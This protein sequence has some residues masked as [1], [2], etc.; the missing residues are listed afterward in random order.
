MTTLE[1]L[2]TNIWYTEKNHDLNPAYFF[3][4][5]SALL[6][7]A[8]IRLRNLFYD[9][10]LLGQ[11]G[12]RCPVISVG[13]L[14]VGGTGK[15]PM[16]I[17]LA[18]LMAGWGLKP[19][20][21][22]RG[23]RGGSGKKVNVVS[24]GRSIL[25]GPGDGGDE[26]L[27]IAGRLPAVPVLTGP[28][29][30]VTGEYA[31]SH[32]GIDI[33]ILDDGFQHRS[34]QRNLDIVLLDGRLPLGNGRLIPRGPLREPF[35]SLKRA[36]LIVLTRAVTGEK[37][38]FESRL[39][40]EL[41]SIPVFKSCHSPRRLTEGR[42]NSRPLSDLA[43]RKIYAFAGVARPDSFRESIESLQGTIVGFRV[44]PDH[45]RYR[46]EDLAELEKEARSLGADLVLT[47]EKDGVKLTPHGEFASRVWTL[48]IELEIIEE[49]ER[50]ETVIRKKLGV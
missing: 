12:L 39:A 19:A 32:F 50:F 15:T 41:P 38:P 9:H 2:L 31:L 7:S 34:L 35:S 44:F 27:L 40:E 20:V 25:S 26:P 46:S 30:S 17:H 10:G 18:G 48:G 14:S 42:E 45:H 23:Y 4:S 33:V 29:R 24:D 47:T 36:D 21:L 1:K 3:L 16:V 11:A 28:R 6:Y 13:N 8:A 37:T 49:A 43:G 22:S 5:F